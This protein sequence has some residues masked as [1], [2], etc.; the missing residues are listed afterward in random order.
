MTVNELIK[1]LKKLSK[2]EREYEVCLFEHECDECFSELTRDT[3]KKIS[4]LYV[5]CHFSGEE[6]VLGEPKKTIFL[7]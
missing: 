3:I 6:E 5:S 1:A 2:E 4:K 7:D